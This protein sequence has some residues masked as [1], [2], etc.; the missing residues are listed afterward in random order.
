MLTQ[1]RASKFRPR[2]QSC[3]TGFGATISNMQ[4]L[5]P[6]RTAMQLW[7]NSFGSLVCWFALFCQA[8]FLLGLFAQG[9]G[10]LYQLEP[11]ARFLPIPSL[12]AAA[13][14]VM[15]KKLVAALTCIAPF[16][17]YGLIVIH[18]LSFDSFLFR[19]PLP[20]LLLITVAQI[21]KSS[22]ELLVKSSR[23]TKVLGCDKQHA[24]S[25]SKI[26]DSNR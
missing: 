20:T 3:K 26:S 19:V 12:P 7:A 24:I 9:Y 4:S 23:Q 25:P 6:S 10:G 18:V 8:A 14:F 15:R 16:A 5:L 22:W 2:Q 21:I 13:I 11:L 1:R 17:V